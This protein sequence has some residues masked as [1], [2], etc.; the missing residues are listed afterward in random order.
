[1]E[2]GDHICVR[3]LL[4]PI[5]YM[6]HGIYISRTEIIHFD[7]APLRDNRDSTICYT[8]LHKFS[9]GDWTGVI[10]YKGYFHFSYAEVIERAMSRVGEHGYNLF[11]W[12][13]EHFATWCV[14]DH[15]GSRQAAKLIAAGAGG[16][17]RAGVG[18]PGVARAL[19]LRNA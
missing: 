1:M 9:P 18:G 15:A 6:H 13:C 14:T 10:P 19:L 7:G 8:T 12:N 17:A 2:P 4:G 3:R 16:R 5:P 11:T